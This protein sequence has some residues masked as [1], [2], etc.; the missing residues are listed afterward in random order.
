MPKLRQGQTKTMYCSV[1]KSVQTVQ[2][3][4]NPLAIKPWTFR[5]SW[6]CKR[7]DVTIAVEL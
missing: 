1:C 3:V 2:S 7:C 5:K 6:T 4:I